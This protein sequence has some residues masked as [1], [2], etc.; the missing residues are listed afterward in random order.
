MSKK[1]DKQTNPSWGGRFSEQTDAFVEAF[2]ASVDFDRRLYLQ[3]IAGSKAHAHMLQKTGVLDD[4]DCEAIVS[5]L[6]TIIEEIESGRFE[7]RVSAEDVHMN[8]EARLTELIGDAG[9]R[10]HTGRSRNDQ[11]ATDIRLYLRDQ[12]DIIVSQ[13]AEFQSGLL[14]L[15][16][17]EADTIMPGFTHLQ[18]AQPVSFGHHMLAWFEMLQRDAGRMHGCRKRMNVSPL[19]AAA[20]AGTSYPI[21]RQMT[22]AEL[23]FS[24]PAANSLDA[25]SDRDFAIEFCA[26]SA[27]LMTHLSRMAEELVMW[28]SAQFDF[29]E[30]PDRYCTGSSIMPQ[31][32]NPDVP[33]LVRGKTGRVNGNLVSLLTLMKS[34]PLAYNKDNQEDKEPLFDTIDTV[35]GSLRAFAD[36]VPALQCKRD[37]MYK[38][39]KQGFSTATDLADYLVRK[40]LPFR[41]AHEVVGKAVAHGVANSRDLSDMTLDELKGFSDRIDEDVFEVLSLEGSVA[42]RNHIG[43]TAPE[44]VRKAV[45]G[46][47]Q[48]L[49]GE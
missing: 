23:G 26:A 14:D 43:G 49:K 40:G 39:A 2:T 7:W 6:D 25:V 47:R 28:S 35:V 1:D 29:I 32:K 34:Q 11:V 18:V 27:I 41:D 8:I 42:A 5:G 20:L 13:L 24:A 30:L 33:E 45:A 19:G 9:K 15:A 46:A 10:L 36:M 21:D 4:S 44:Q 16:E 17:R 22:A 12:I 37:N 38:A 3:D 48:R 31:K